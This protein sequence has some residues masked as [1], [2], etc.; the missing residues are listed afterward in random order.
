M[1][2]F[3]CIVSSLFSTQ[4]VFSCPLMTHVTIY[5]LSCCGLC[6]P[7]LLR[8]QT[9]PV[10]KLKKLHWISSPPC[11]MLKALFSTNWV[12]PDKSSSSASLHSFV[13]LRYRTGSGLMG[14]LDEI[15]CFTLFKSRGWDLKKKMQEK[16][17]AAMRTRLQR[18]S[19]WAPTW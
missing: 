12:I 11:V 18:A 4:L 17:E 9:L 10:G 7:L 15:W 3:Q 13:C 2:F 19:K 1:R 6:N 16:F 5:D 8:W 14:Q